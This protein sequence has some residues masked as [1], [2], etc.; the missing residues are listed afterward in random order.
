M[1]DPTTD[2]TKKTKAEIAR[3]NGAKSHGP[4]TPEGKARSSHNSYKHGFTANALVIPDIETEEE[5]DE[6]KQ[7]IKDTWRPANPVEEDLV[8]E[9]AVCKWQERRMWR[10][11]TDTFDMQIQNQESEYKEHYFDEG[12]NGRFAY[13]F[14]KLA[15]TTK[16]LDLMLRYRN[17]INR[18]Y[19]RAMNQLLKL[20]KDRVFENLPAAPAPAPGP[21][22]EQQRNEPTPEPK[23]NKTN[24]QPP[25]SFEPQPTGPAGYHP[26]CTPDTP[27]TPPDSPAS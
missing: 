21:A 20:R 25:E 1:F 6:A 9:M 17:S 22:Q 15:D 18:Q 23:P 8:E 13:G 5:F 12:G 2:T 27:S 26:N 4:V 10:C 24:T 7:R 3:E 11:E 16:R 19:H 14:G